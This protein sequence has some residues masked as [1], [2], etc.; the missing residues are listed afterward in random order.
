MD[1]NFGSKYKMPDMGNMKAPKFGD[2]DWKDDISEKELEELFRKQGKQFGSTTTTTT[3]S[4]GSTTTTTTTS[5]WSS[6]SMGGMSLQ[7]RVKR[8]EAKAAAKMAERAQQPKK[9]GFFSNFGSAGNGNMDIA[10]LV[11]QQMGGGQQSSDWKGPTLKGF[12][13]QH[14]SQFVDEMMVFQESEFEKKLEDEPKETGIV[15]RTKQKLRQ[16]A[17]RAMF[18]FTHKIR[19]IMARGMLR[20]WKEQEE[21]ENR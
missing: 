19:G 16:N 14:L 3:S 21:K 5:F 6:G 8:A 17:E 12:D 9:P 4:D 2:I 20:K 13:H 11:Q 10:S 18:G 7:E 1:E 15:A